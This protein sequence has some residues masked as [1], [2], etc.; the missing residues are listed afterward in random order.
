MVSE[1]VR[2]RDLHGAVAGAVGRLQQADGG[3]EAAAALITAMRAA[4][5]GP[6]SAEAIGLLGQGWTG[7]EALAIA[8][9]CALT[10]RSFRSGVL[11]AVNHDGDSDSTGAICGNLL[12]AALGAAAIECDL[13]GGLEGRD[14]IAQVADDLH[15]AFASGQPPSSQRYPA[16]QED[17]HSE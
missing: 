11:H 17:D 7:E 13:L 8:V 14:V 4:E 10:A 9:H 5:L 6:L 15:D 1:L 2:G 12:G 3:E 16:G